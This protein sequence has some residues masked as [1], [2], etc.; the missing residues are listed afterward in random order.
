M[1]V[2]TTDPIVEEVRTRGRALTQRLRG[3][4]DEGTRLNATI[5]Q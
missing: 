5:E 4:A 2:I 1:N 3:S